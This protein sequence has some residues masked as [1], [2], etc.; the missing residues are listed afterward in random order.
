[1]KLEIIDE[2]EDNTGTLRMNVITGRRHEMRTRKIR[3]QGTRHAPSLSRRHREL[4]WANR[5]GVIVCITR[6]AV[7]RRRTWRKPA[8]MNA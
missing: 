8:V 5:V 6:H 2:S 3:D 7:L 4:E 1:M